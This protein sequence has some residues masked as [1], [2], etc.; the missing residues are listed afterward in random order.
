MGA[1]LDLLWK[2]YPEWR[3]SHDPRVDALRDFDADGLVDDW[4]IKYG[5]DPADASDGNADSDGDGVSNLDEYYA[6][7]HP[8]VSIRAIED[9]FYPNTRVTIQA[10]DK[11]GI[12]IRYSADGSEPGKNTRRYRKPIRINDSLTFKATAFIGKRRLPTEASTFDLVGKIHHFRFDGSHPDDQIKDDVG[13]KSPHVVGSDNVKRWAPGRIGNAFR[14]DGNGGYLSFSS[15]RQYSHQGAIAMWVYPEQES[16]GKRYL[17]RTFRLPR[18]QIELTSTEQQLAVRV[19]DKNLAVRGGDLPIKKWTHIALVWNH[20]AV[21]LFRN[22]E[23]VDQ[24]EYQ[25]FEA[26]PAPIS[27]GG[28]YD[29]AT[30]SFPGRLDDVQVYNRPMSAEEVKDLYESAPTKN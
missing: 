30:A 2:V 9:R 19:G 28:S 10:I 26:A 7:T 6:A 13:L 5:L 27:L 21:F 11:P 14:V 4:E 22:G 1:D 12:E 16:V 29:D 23:L 15:D 3:A 20:G 24:G 18:N 8:T 17:F 25:D